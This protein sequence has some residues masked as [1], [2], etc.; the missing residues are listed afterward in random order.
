MS[1]FRIPNE[2]GQIRLIPNSD[3]F[4]ELWDTYNIDLTTIFGK[5]KA[6]KR[7]VKVLDE[8]TDLNGDEP[9]AFCIYKTYYYIITNNSDNAYVCSV[10]DDVTD[11][12]NWVQETDLSSGLVASAGTDAVVFNGKMLISGTSNIG[13]WDGSTYDD[14][15]WTTV[16]S[17]SALTAG[18]IPPP[19]TMHVHRGGQETL[20]VTDSNLVRYYN[21]TS[22]HS[23]VTLQSDLT[24]CCV[25]SGV[26][27][28]WVGT[29]TETQDNAY[30]YEIYVGE[31]LDGTPIAR[32]AYKIDG[33]AVL[34][35]QV[36][37]NVPYIFTEKGHIQ[38]F[39]G[40]GF[41]TVASLPF[42]FTEQYLDGVRAGLVQDSN[43]ARP[44]HPKGMQANNDSL[45]IHINTALYNVNDYPT[46]AA[47]GIWEYNRASKNL[48]HR[49]GFCD[50]DTQKG[51]RIQA[52]SGPIM[53]VDT[54]DTLLMVA[55]R[56]YGGDNGV[57][58]VSNTS[59][60]YGMF[61]T[62]EIDS[63]TI[64]DAIE[65]A[66]IKAKTLASG[67]SIVLKYRNRKQDRQLLTG[68]FSATNAFNVASVVTGVSVGD[69]VTLLDGDN[70]GY[71]AH[72]T[73]ISLSAHTTVFTLDDD[74]G[75]IGTSYLLEIQ[76]WKKID[77][78]YTADDGEYKKIGVGDTNTWTQYKIVFNGDIELRQFLSKG[79]AKTEI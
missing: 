28:T 3:S 68:I 8:N 40:S 66:Y 55:S 12:S 18:T 76:N 67:E 77:D 73:N 52:D 36:I 54:S 31:E 69:E 56:I 16:I 48:T 11:A 6:S 71:T 13:S 32:N 74:I 64:Q 5:I 62:A 4:G 19:H 45:F 9:V 7:L 44:V 75:T 57:F 42:A 15:W 22:G 30:V 47:S 59:T 65:N 61:I 49:F 46:R 79:N 26:S 63:G 27:A 20:F 14:D 58:M 43:F 41:V 10:T 17:G 29:Y 50:T 78:V 39:N 34:S 51:A 35:I 25:A 33:R 21:A 24:A 2:Q 60:P 38:V 70:V 72:I 1:V 23:T 53:M 37:D